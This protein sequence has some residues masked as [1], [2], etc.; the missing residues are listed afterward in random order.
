VNEA[1]MGVEPGTWGAYYVTVATGVFG[2]RVV[3]DVLVRQAP[4]MQMRVMLKDGTS[5]ILPFSGPSVDFIRYIDGYGNEVRGYSAD[6]R[7]TWVMATG[8]VI[9]QAELAGKLT[10]KVAADGSVSLVDD[11]GQEWYAQAAPVGPNHI[12]QPWV[13]GEQYDELLKSAM[14]SQSIKWYGQI[15]AESGGDTSSGVGAQGQRFRLV[16]DEGFGLNLTPREILY[17]EATAASAAQTARRI[18]ATGSAPGASLAEESAAIRARGRVPTPIPETDSTIRG[19]QA[20]ADLAAIKDREEAAT[21]RLQIGQ[22]LEDETAAIKARKTPGSE[23]RAVGAVA[24]ALTEQATP[25]LQGIISL[26][27]ALVAAIVPPTSLPAPYVAPSSLTFTPA[28][29]TPLP[30]LKAVTPVALPKVPVT[31]PLVVARGA[32]PTPSGTESRI[33]EPVVKPVVKA[34]VP[35]VKAPVPVQPAKP[36]YLPQKT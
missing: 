32:T 12:A 15:A 5:Q 9:P 29:L 23:W 35:V 19:R 30:T 18:V 6:G 13:F 8:G 24:S 21:A 34:P 33:Y 7:K 28:P 31:S 3:G 10:K 11:Q 4:A 25:F 22:S 36:I 27:T 17:T 26:G 20:Y 1:D 2:V 14:A 16:R